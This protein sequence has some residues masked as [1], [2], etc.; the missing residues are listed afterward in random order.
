M[1]YIFFLIQIKRT[2]Q[3]HSQ[4]KYISQTDLKHYENELLY[5]YMRISRYSD[6][7]VN[8]IKSVW[9]RNYNDFDT[10]LSSIRNSFRQVFDEE[11]AHRYSIEIRGKDPV[12]GSLYGIDLDVNDFDLGSFKSMV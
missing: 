6:A 10:A 9:D 7:D 1:L 8:R 12:Y 4:P 5:I 3:N 11:I 2:N